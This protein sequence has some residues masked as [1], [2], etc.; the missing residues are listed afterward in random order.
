MFFKKS[1]NRVFY[2]TLFLFVFLFST[3]LAQKTTP[4]HVYLY[5]TNKVMCNPYTFDV[6]FKGVDIYSMKK[7]TALEYQFFSE[8]KLKIEVKNWMNSWSSTMWLNIESGKKYYVKIDCN[9]SGLSVSTNPSTGYNEWLE[10]SKGSVMNML[11]DPNVPLLETIEG[12]NTIVKTRTDTVKQIVYVNAPPAKKHSYEPFADVDLNI[13]SGSN[14]NDL[15]FAL[16][17]GNEDYAS[18]QTDLKIEVNV[19]F[20]KNDASTFK[21]YV[22]RS[23]GVPEKNVTMLHDATYGQMNQ[24]IS[25]IN[26]IAKNTNGKARIIFYYAGH[27]MPDENSKEAYLIPVDISGANV[28]SAIKLKDVYAKLT[29]SASEQVV[30]FL[31]ACFTG[32]ARNQGLLAS[33]GIAIKPKEEF[34]NGNIAVF[35][36]SSGSQSSLSYQEK[37]HGLYTYY[38]LKKLQESKGDVSLKDLSAYLKEKVSLEAVLINSKEQNPQVNTSAEALEKWENWKLK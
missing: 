7:N 37:R 20:A 27:G 25:K 13:P 4:A 16:I 12:G 38:L 28:S 32:G 30:V 35:S 29:E 8:G 22:T 33:R 34:L 17:I 18:Q 24:A 31:D 6:Q 26:M 36:S 10:A 3:L 21:E 9:L 2:L 5:R 1:K 15:T 11:E 23:L 19:E 14:T